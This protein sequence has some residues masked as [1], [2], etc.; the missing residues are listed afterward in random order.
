MFRH[1]DQAITHIQGYHR[2]SNQYTPLKVKPDN[3]TY[4]WSLGPYVQLPFAK[5]LRGQNHSSILGMKSWFHSDC[6]IIAVIL[7][8]LILPPTPTLE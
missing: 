1:K 4:S 6:L 3:K 5:C 2:D 7:G 8:Y